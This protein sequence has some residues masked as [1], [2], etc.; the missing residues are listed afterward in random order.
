[1]VYKIFLKDVGNY[2]T[3]EFNNLEDATEY[4]HELNQYRE[5]MAVV[6]RF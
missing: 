2:S 5:N 6:V 4:V 1:M 3:T